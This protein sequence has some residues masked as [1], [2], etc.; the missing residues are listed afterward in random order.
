MKIMVVGYGSIGKRHVNNIINL[1]FKP[2]VVTRYPD[3]NNAVFLNS[4]SDCKNIDYAIIATP[5]GD[6][7]RD[8]SELAKSGCKNILIEKPVELSINKALDIQKLALQ[9]KICTHVAY[10]LR[11]YDVFD[12][13]KELM[14]NTIERIRLVKITVGQYLPEWRPNSDYQKS[15]SA[16]RNNGGGVD[17]DLSHEIDYMYWLFG[18]PL[19]ID[20]VKRYKISS[21]N[22]NSPDL[23]KA[24]Y[25]YSNF[26]IDVEMDY[27]RCKERSLRILGENEEIAYVDFI[28]KKG[29]LIAQD[30]LT[31]S[32]FSLDDSYNFEISEFLGIKKINKLATLDT[33][34]KVLELLRLER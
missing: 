24:V 15:Y 8:Y 11:F 21:L 4:I 18:Y 2:F 12:K 32:D 28:N 5:T 17:L 23:F 6:H 10:N 20:F 14:N 3:T 30:Q 7:L 26:I 31:P 22:I 1:G 34:I 16:H 29:Q 19:E 27:I 9:N 33:G 25:R 13:I